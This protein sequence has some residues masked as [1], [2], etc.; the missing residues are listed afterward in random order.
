MDAKTG[1]VIINVLIVLLCVCVGVG[2]YMHKNIM[3]VEYHQISQP[4]TNRIR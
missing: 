3:T 4:L 1:N 2:I